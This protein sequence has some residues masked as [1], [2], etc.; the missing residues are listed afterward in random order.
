[1]KVLIV[2][3]YFF[4]YNKAICKE[5]NRR[6]IKCFT[7][8]EIHSNSVIVKIAYRLNLS[9]LFREKIIIHRETLYSF[10][11]NNQISDVLFI[12]PDIINDDFLIEVKKRAKVH[13]YMWDGFKNKKNAFSV[14]KY[15]NT[16]SSF[17][18]FDCQHYGMN[19]VP[20][21]AE[22]EYRTRSVK[23]K[24]DMSFCGTIHSDRPSWIKALLKYS[25]KNR[26]SLGLF[27]Y[28]YSPLLL[29]IRLTLN[30]FCF[31]L[32][33]KVSYE[34]FPKKD[35]ADLF[36]Q[37]RVV[38]DLTHPNQN[39]FTSRTFEALRTG[40]KLATNNINC[41][42]L[43]KEFPSR[44]FVFGKNNFQEKAFLDFI[45]LD[46]EPLNEK[47][48]RFLSVERFTDQ[49]LESIND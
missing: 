1:M 46:V 5:I 13:L 14:L 2:G 4:S 15:F 47:Q 11:D 40:S 32:F 42:I 27:L 10:I 29:F 34:P 6:N 35:I 44:I 37:S 48:D 33:S 49:I 22:S 43:Q 16:K 28:Y 25:N 45:R 9:F 36:R 30:K 24:Y 3:P 23:K 39:G 41:E 18:M 21:F 20:L 7:Y 8:N 26:L 12:S 31:D 19:Y 17:D 38:V